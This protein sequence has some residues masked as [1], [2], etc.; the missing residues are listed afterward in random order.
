MSKKIKKI[1]DEVINNAREDRKAA[2]S[3]LDD[4]AAYIG[5]AQERHREV[6]LTAAKYL[7]TLQKT[8]EQLVKIADLLQD[9]EK[10]EYGD[11]D[12]KDKEELY[13]QI[14][15]DPKPDVEQ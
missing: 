6:G 2:S 14:E 1:L 5:G 12:S 8:N 15:E 13:K 9:F 4:V 10:D 11:L 3:L 7:E